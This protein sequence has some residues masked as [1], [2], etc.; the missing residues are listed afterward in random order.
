MELDS[1][2]V[3]DTVSTW[4]GPI[5]T[6]SSVAVVR[7]WN[8]AKDST[9]FHGSGFWFNE[10]LTYFRERDSFGM[11]RHN[12]VRR[13]DKIA[14]ESLMLGLLLFEIFLV[15]FLMTKGLKLIGKYTRLTLSTNTSSEY[16]EASQTGGFSLFLWAIT[17][18][19]FSLM[20]HVLIN[21]GAG[22]HKHGLDSLFMLRL[23]VYTFSFFIVQ[24]WIYRMV[25]SVFF[26][27]AQTNR[28]ISNNKT[29][30]FFFA[31]ILS[32][33]LI[34]AEI[35]AITNGTFVLIWAI[36][37]LVLYKLWM[38]WRTARI[39]SVGEGAFLYFILYLCALEILPILL[40]Y[41]GLFLL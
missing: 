32:P 34:G 16:E 20:G 15:A 9:L 41:K 40:Y 29:F 19:V 10:V 22:T 37:F 36:V 33:V 39:F 6:D 31:M 2:T 17:L 3:K 5:C 13:P 24:H 38:L 27:A 26:S 30:L 7:Q 23:F 28:W 14:S 11:I 35:G 18:I 8:Y 1:L 21:T 4:S 12:A 25:G